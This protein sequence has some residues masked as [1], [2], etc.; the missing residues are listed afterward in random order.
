MQ[1]GLFT[2]LQIRD[3]TLQNRSVVSAMC[4]Y[5]AQADGVARVLHEAHLTRFALGG[6]ALIFT[7][8]TAISPTGRIS[9]GDLGI[10]TDRQTERLGEI[11]RKIK[12][13]G[14]VPG[15]Q[16]SHAGRKG[17]GIAPWAARDACD[18]V[19]GFPWQ[20]VAPSDVPAPGKPA[21][22]ALSGSEIEQL[23]QDWIVAAKRADAAGFEVLELHGAHGYLLHQ[24]LSPLTNQRT[25]EWGGS[26][27]NRMRFPLEVVRAVRAVWPAG[28]P[29][30]YRMSVSDGANMHWTLADSITFAR[31]LGD[32]GVDVVDCSGG[33]IEDATHRAPP[34]GYGFQVPSAAA[35]KRDA[36]V[37]TMAVGLITHAR[38]ANQILADGHADLVALAR[39]NLINPNWTA[40]ARQELDG[41][42]S[43]FPPQFSSFL[44]RWSDVLAN[45]PPQVATA[46]PTNPRT[47]RE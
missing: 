20:T 27:E 47:A 2:P 15:I 31:H 39:Q 38:Q 26:L 25:D 36:G 18:G 9:P 7:E 16:I 42:F 19:E 17:S 5:S 45:L 12:E 37:K 14:S 28:K 10:Y 34:S 35:L 13:L 40:L 46:D 33:G 4:L 6:A 8:A 11:T 21:P 23:L 41:D 24:F 43:D 32:L 29:L 1:T 3:L 22:R 44:S 30:F